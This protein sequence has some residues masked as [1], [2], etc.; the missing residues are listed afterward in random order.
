MSTTPVSGF[1]N[2]LQSHF[3]HR[4]VDRN[5]WDYIAA[6]AAILTSDTTRAPALRPCTPWSLPEASASPVIL[7]QGPHPWR[8]LA[9]PASD[10]T[11]SPLL[12]YPSQS[13]HL[14]TPLNAVTFQDSLIP[15][16]L[17]YMQV[18]DVAFRTPHSQSHLQITPPCLHLRIIPFSKGLALQLF[19]P[20]LIWH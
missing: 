11:P 16:L 5:T 15:F 20:S 19:L 3:Q 1:S 10:S 8:A 17:V 9:L 18:E 2:T 14:L 4:H 6:V 12:H 13:L 7:S